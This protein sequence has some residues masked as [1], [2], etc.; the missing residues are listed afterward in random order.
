M[1]LLKRLNTRIRVDQNDNGIGLQKLKLFKKM[2]LFTLNQF[3]SP[4]DTHNPVFSTNYGYWTIIDVLSNSPETKHLRLKS[5][6]LIRRF[7]YLNEDELNDEDLNDDDD[8]NDD[9]SD[10]ED[11][12][13]NNNNHLNNEPNQDLAI[14]EERPF[15]INNLEFNFI[16]RQFKLLETIQ[17]NWC[18]IE[19]ITIKLNEKKTDYYLNEALNRLILCLSEFRNL[20]ILQIEQIS[21]KAQ[22][23]S[24]NILKLIECCDQLSQLHIG[25][26][27]QITPE[28]VDA[29]LKRAIQNP[30]IN[31]ELKFKNTVSYEIVCPCNLMIF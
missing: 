29:F 22:I 1:P 24:F 9:L 27:A 12:D 10:I 18:S 7:E 17:S 31:Y 11:Q 2:E 15:Q 14:N 19:Q 21:D 3:I 16:N 30:Q 5:L 20:K 26:G 25:L 6:P 28:I 13:F 4:A 23:N 8:L